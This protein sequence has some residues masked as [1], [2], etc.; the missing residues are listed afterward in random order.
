M[1]NF[2]ECDFML[3]KIDGV[4]FVDGKGITVHRNRAHHG[5]AFRTSGDNLR[6]D[7]LDGKTLFWNTNEI[8]YFPK[9]SSY[10]IKIQNKS[11]STCYA[12]NFEIS[13]DISFSPFSFKTKDSQTF[14]NIFKSINTTWQEKKPGYHLKCKSL[15]YSVF[16]KIQSEY[17]LAYADKNK[18]DIIRPAISYIH[19]NYTTDALS[20]TS[21]S[22]MCNVTP[23]YF[24][25]IFNQVQGTSPVKFIHSLRLTRAEE[26]I[27]SGFYQIS[28]IAF[29]S[30]FN[31]ISYF[32]REFKKAYGVSP[33]KYA[34]ALKK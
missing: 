5:I 33:R 11:L 32:S 15:L 28:E 26:L 10:D 18:L 23:E 9:N 29:L 8:F 30:G 4:C 12:I 25:K 24:R 2:M 31:D 16:Y 13:N 14:I 27:S 22:E 21:L 20:I 19:E 1:K 34:E 6:Y 3:K 17:Q 7:F